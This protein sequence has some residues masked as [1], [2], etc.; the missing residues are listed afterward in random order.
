MDHGG[1]HDGGDDAID[2]D[3]D[4]DDDK[5]EEDIDCDDMMMQW[6]V[7]RDKVTR[8]MMRR[9]A[10][11]TRSDP[12]MGHWHRIMVMI[13]ITLILML[14][15]A[16]MMIM[17]IYD[18]YDGDDVQDVSEDRSQLLCFNVGGKKYFVLR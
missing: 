13:M 15:R 5:E 17:M 18:N 7:R 14:M 10:R 11:I 2:D 3:D 16:M 12:D 8:I 9:I 6:A 4:D 1:T